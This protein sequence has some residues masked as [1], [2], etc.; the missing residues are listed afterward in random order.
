MLLTLTS[1]IRQIHEKDRSSPD[2]NHSQDAALPAGRPSASKNLKR[3]GY[4][5]KRIAPSVLCLVM[6]HQNSRYQTGGT[7]PDGPVSE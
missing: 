6:N 3:R 4:S 1:E 5:K 2:A 7:G